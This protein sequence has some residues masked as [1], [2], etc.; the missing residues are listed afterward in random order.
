[1]HDLWR[2]QNL[3]ERRSEAPRSRQYHL[4]RPAQLPLCLKEKGA[5]GS[6]SLPTSSNMMWIE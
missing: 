2:D 4:V 5:G 1:M 3:R 6:H